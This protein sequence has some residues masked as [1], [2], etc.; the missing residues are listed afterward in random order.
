MQR[1]HRSSVRDHWVH[2][3]LAALLLAI[4]LPAVPVA[5]GTPAAAEVVGFSDA[6]AAGAASGRVTSPVVISEFLASASSAEY[7]G[8]DWNGDGVIG[9]ESDQFI[10]LHNSGGSAVDIGGWWLDDV[11]HESSSSACQVGNGTT[12]QPDGRLAFFRARTQIELDYYGGDTV[13][14]L[15]ESFAVLDEHTYPDVDSQFDVP[16]VRNVVG[17]FDKSG[18][19]TPG[20]APGDNP[21]APS[22]GGTCYTPLDYIH[23]GAYALRGRLVTMDSGGVIDDG[24]IMV[25]DGMIAALWDVGGGQS[26]PSTVTVNGVTVDV[27]DVEVVNTSGTIYPGLIDMHNHM[28]YN[29]LPLWNYE[30]ANGEFYTNRYQWRNNPGYKPEVTWAKNFVQQS[31]YWNLEPQSLKYAEMKLLAGGTTSVQGNPTHDHAEYASILAR[32][33]EHDNFGR[34]YIH[35]KVSELTDTYQG[36]HIKTGNA[37]GTLDA[38]FLHLAEGTDASSLYE[39]DI[40]Q[41]NDLLVGEVIIIH[42][43]PLGPTEFAAMADVGASLAWSPTSN[44]LLYGDTAD[45]AAAKAAGVRISLAPDW[46]PS[47]S[48]SPMHELKTADWWNDHKLDGAFSSRELVEMV[49][50][51]PVDSMNWQD[52]TGR[53][54]AG[55]AAD[56]V[57]IDSFHADPYRNLIEAIDPDLRLTIAAGLPIIGDVDLMSALNGDDYE[58]VD[59]EGFTKAIDVTFRGVP[60]GEESWSGIESRL[61]AAMQFDRTAM[62]ENFSYANSMTRDAFDSWIDGSYGSLDAIPLDPIFTFG[63]DRY[64]ASLNGSQPFNS[65]G[66][67]DLWSIYYAVELD[68][69]GHRIGS[70]APGYNGSGGNGGGDGGGGGNGGGNGGA[71]GNGGDGGDDTP[72]WNDDPVSVPTLLPTYGPL[73]MEAWPHNSSLSAGIHLEVCNTNETH[74]D[75]RVRACGSIVILTDPA[76][77]CYVEDAASGLNWTEPCASRAPWSRMHEDVSEEAAN[78][79]WPVSRIDP[80]RGS[81]SAIAFPGRM[82]GDA[83]VAQPLVPADP[84]NDSSSG[85][86]VRADDARAGVWLC[87]QASKWVDA[88]AESSGDDG[89]GGDLTGEGEGVESQSWLDSNLYYV[90][91]VAALFILITSMAAI[92]MTLRRR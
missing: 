17:G 21:L 76:S 59:G 75:G 77:G 5:P 39:F 13:R 58:V 74:A 36:N 38:W 78:G 56:I 12:L 8:T 51:N 15:D 60:F 1:R 61:S 87:R 43:V 55:L 50:I 73:G 72:D 23:R 28:H 9:Q 35:T 33:I 22:A 4:A 66:D 71:G 86:A 85:D 11:G 65:Q 90:V 91:L 30:L 68:E 46:A 92:V 80:A 70:G 10:E 2:L 44:L 42:G 62:Y 48:K 81:G 19:P 20:W 16:Y 67:I 53:L 88:P 69:G 54:R 14:L 84:A 52:E 34:D 24:A 29:Y 18:S 49:T 64:F 27:S 47:G 6:A 32:N 26:A 57:V 3:V 45:V 31:N 7:N 89:G 83:V 40:L 37:S 82:C 79:S 41:Q 25:V 63:D